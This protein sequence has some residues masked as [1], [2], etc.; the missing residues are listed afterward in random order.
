MPTDPSI[1]ALNWSKSQ[2]CTTQTL[3]EDANQSTKQT[4]TPHTNQLRQ[5]E[6]G[7]VVYVEL[8]EVGRKFDQGE[9]FGVVESVK[10]WTGGRKMGDAARGMLHDYAASFALRMPNQQKGFMLHGR[11]CMVESVK[12]WARCECSLPHAFSWVRL[13]AAWA[14]VPALCPFL[15]PAG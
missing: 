8:P 11:V 4:S 14:C 2:P 13:H 1:R 6:L 15:S 7:D 10:V 5:S 3:L 9:T 12:A